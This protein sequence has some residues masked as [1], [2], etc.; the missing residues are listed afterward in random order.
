MTDNYHLL[1]RLA[2]LMLKIDQHLL[3]IDLLF[4]DENIGDFVKSIQIDSP[5]Q[6]MLMEGV[7]TESI[8]DEKLFVSF[9]VEGYYHYVL[10]EVIYNQAEGKSVS[11]LKK[12][13]EEKRLKG[14]RE[15]V[16]QCLIRDVQK[17]DLTRLLFLIDEGSSFLE[18]CCIPLASAFLIINLIYRKD[19]KNRNIEY[20]YGLKKILN[21]L[22]SCQSKND[23]KV[24]QKVLN[25]LKKT[26]HQN[27]IS[28]LYIII[29]ET[30]TPDNLLNAILYVRSFEYL[31][32]DIRSQK[33]KYLIDIFKPEEE[34]HELSSFY[35]ILSTQS[36][37]NE[38]YELALEYIGKSWKIA[39]VNKKATIKVK[40]EYFKSLA[41]IYQGKK[42]YTKAI[43]YFQKAL[44]MSLKKY[45]EQSITVAFINNSIGFAC[46]LNKKYDEGFGYLEKSLHVFVK[47][48][49]NYHVNISRNYM[50]YA[51]ALMAKKEY[52]KAI[53]FYHKSI[54]IESKIYGSKSKF[55]AVL[56]QAIGGAWKLLKDYSKA[57][58]FFNESLIIFLNSEED[59]SDDIVD[60][61][62]MIAFCYNKLKY[63]TLSIENYK[64]ALLNLQVH[65][66]DHNK[67]AGDI[68]NYI[69]LN[70]QM[71][72]DY[73]LAMVNIEK[74]LKIR[75]ALSGPTDNDVAICYNNL[76]G[77]YFKNKSYNKAAEYFRITLDIKL[78]I[79]GY[80][81]IQLINTYKNIGK[82]LVKLL[83]F[84]EALEFFKLGFK[85]RQSEDLL[86][87]IAKCYEGL[88]Q[89]ETALNFFI[90]AAELN[91]LNYGF[92]N[93]TTKIYVKKCL[94]L[95]RTLDKSDSLPK[96]I[97]SFENVV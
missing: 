90:R 80:E 35:S 39:L 44:K 60:V 72:G 71:L 91:K 37:I 42:N 97:K 61:Y 2:E 33:I 64:K 40:I 77:V 3:P 1:Y 82:T 24:L 32:K 54:V 88:Q 13:V 14:V 19:A 25:H 38:N 43:V 30:L 9:T 58:S 23:I 85:I 55:V 27:L 18:L 94:E 62:T 57:L 6:K 52:E 76:A 73:R 11:E 67:K 75:L 93:D 48:F 49:G 96:W 41:L 59:H 79:Y 78:K 51:T 68:Y 50:M 95:A 20:F 17:N 12:I 66:G 28:D 10:G 46:L 7:L 70:C 21:N 74:S 84:S 89:F 31:P 16:E 47:I 56:F 26:Q 5:Y 29:N 81:H 53:D 65:N 45:S 8:K 87:L 69:G 15:G 34:S 4:D 36:R 83:D 22:L 92:E 86:F 63:Y